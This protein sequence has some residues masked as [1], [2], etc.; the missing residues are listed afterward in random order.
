[1]EYI[2]LEQQ[3]NTYP[4]IS[5]YSKTSL[6]SITLTGN[7]DTNKLNFII[8]TLDSLVVIPDTNFRF[9]L[10][11]DEKVYTSPLYYNELITSYNESN[12]YFLKSSF[13]EEFTVKYTPNDIVNLIAQLKVL[14]NTKNINVTK[15]VFV[16]S[17]GSYDYIALIKYIDW[18]V[19]PV[20]LND[21][22]S[23]GVLSPKELSSYILPEIPIPEVSL[24]TVATVEVVEENI[25]AYEWEYIRKKNLD[26]EPLAVRET[27]NTTSREIYRINE[28]NKFIGN[29]LGN[30]L[31]E[32]FDDART[33]R[34]GYVKVSIDYANRRF[35]RLSGPFNIKI[36]TIKQP[37]NS[38]S[39]TTTTPTNTTPTQP[40]MSGGGGGGGGGSYGGGYN[41][42]RDP[43]GSSNN[44]QYNQR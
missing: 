19:S 44:V 24:G 43:I 18:L 22:E 16:L 31:F 33:A 12:P 9:L 25:Q 13:L 40:P 17:D 7:F 41:D 4:T 35:K 26:R 8:P 14:E 36:L 15:N 32:I 28:G 30:G 42:G 5:N 11:I 2:I 29:S 21:L 6:D 38:S 34:V 1:M 20:R 23:N 27:Q 10:S 3:Q 39:N 37:S